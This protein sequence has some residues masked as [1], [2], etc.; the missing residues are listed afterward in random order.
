MRCV[1]VTV[2]SGGGGRDES[3]AK[4]RGGVSPQQSFVHTWLPTPSASL[5]VK[6]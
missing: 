6:S 2:M 3:G 5:P 1:T 4:Q